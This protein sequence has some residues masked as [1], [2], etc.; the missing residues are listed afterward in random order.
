LLLE[1]KEDGELKQLI[2]K[3][4]DLVETEDTPHSFTNQSDSLARYIVIKQVLSGEDKVDLF[5]KDR[6]SDEG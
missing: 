6:Y 5:E 2:V 4:G 3:K 1:W